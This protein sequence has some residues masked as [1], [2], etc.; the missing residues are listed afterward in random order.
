MSLRDSILSAGLLAA[1]GL[2]FI[3]MTSE[4]APAHEPVAAQSNVALAVSATMATTSFTTGVAPQTGTT[5]PKIAATITTAKPARLATNIETPPPPNTQTSDSTNTVTRLQNPYNTP[6]LSFDEVNTQARSALVN[7]LCR[8]GEDSLRPISGSGVII[9]PRGVILTN[10]H[11]AQYVLL[12]ESKD[13]QLTCYV[14]SGSPAYPRWKAAVLYI[15]PSW[16]SDHASAINTDHPTGTGEHDYALL[17]I[18]ETTSGAPLPSSFPYIEP[19]VR[20]RIGFSGDQVLAASYPAELIGGISAQTDIYPVTT[21]TTIRQLLTFKT[22]TVDV[23]SLGGIIEA[24]GGSSGGSVVN[25]WGK[26]IALITTTSEGTTTADRDLRATTLSYIDHDLATE[27][28]HSLSQILSGDISR[29][30]SDFTDAIA[31]GLIQKYIDV[32]SR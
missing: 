18:T 20:E 1:I 15:P 6:P 8:S 13:I 28:Q 19:D 5:S 31:P 11:V 7:I 10:A 24:Q 32:L 25:A 12:S 9:D 4:N 16:V 2:G 27:T 21:I 23:V 3:F 14:R 22:G 29:E 26:L 17:A 30:T